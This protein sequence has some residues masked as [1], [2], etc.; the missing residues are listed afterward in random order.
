MVVMG[1]IVTNAQIATVNGL[2]KYDS[3]P[4][5]IEECDIDNTTATF[6]QGFTNTTE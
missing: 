5:S 6:H 3:L 4:S 2:L 1:F